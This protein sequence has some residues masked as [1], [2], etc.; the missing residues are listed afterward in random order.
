MLGSVVSQYRFPDSK[1][2]LPVSLQ[3]FH[4]TIPFSFFSFFV[5]RDIQTNS[6]YILQTPTEEVATTFSEEV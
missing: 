2:T 4:G 1:H 6:G 5:Q 3:K